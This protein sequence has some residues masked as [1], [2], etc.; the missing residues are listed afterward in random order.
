LAYKKN[1]RRALSGRENALGPDHIS[2]LDTIDDLGSLYRDQGRLAEAE[3]MYERA[4]EGKQKVMGPDHP[5]TL[6]TANLL[7]DLYQSQGRSGEADA[8]M[9]RLKLSDL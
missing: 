5:S 9:Q 4:L 1:S 2:T 7:R 8:V 6:R 3:V